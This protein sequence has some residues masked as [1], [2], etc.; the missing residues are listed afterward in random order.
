MDIYI[1]ICQHILE[2]LLAKWYQIEIC[3]IYTE[4]EIN[5]N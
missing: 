4:F 2:G 3:H 1:V 5:E